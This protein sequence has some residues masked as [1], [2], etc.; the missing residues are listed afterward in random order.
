MA[1]LEL[2]IT[3]VGIIEIGDETN[4]PLR[5]NKRLS[6]ISLLTKRS[7]VYTYE[8]EIIDTKQNKKALQYFYHYK[9]NN[10][11]N[12]DE[13]KECVIKKDGRNFLEGKA[14]VK[15]STI[16]DGVRTFTVQFSG[17]N[18]DWWSELKKYT[19]A[20]LDWTG[21]AAFTQTYANVASTW[22]NTYT[23]GYV[24][25]LIDRGHALL[26]A[27][28]SFSYAHQSTF[29][30]ELFTR[31]VVDLISTKLGIIW[32]SDLFDEAGFKK[33]ILTYFTT[34]QY[35]LTSTIISDNHA[36]T[37]LSANGSANV[38]I[39]G[40][41]AT[42][43]DLSTVYSLPFT[44]WT[45]VIDTNSIVNSNGH[46]T[47]IL[48]GSIYKV[49]VNIN[50]DIYG[51]GHQHRVYFWMRNINNGTI[52]SGF[53]GYSNDDF[54]SF[55]FENTSSGSD[56]L[57][58]EFYLEAQAGDTYE[59]IYHI[60]DV[61][62][63]PNPNIAPYIDDD[64]NYVEPTISLTPNP[65][66][67][68]ILSGSRIEYEVVG[69]TIAHGI[70]SF[71]IGSIIDDT[72][73]LF[74]IFNDLVRTFNLYAE[75]DSVSNVVKIEPRKDFYGTIA[76]A[77]NL[78]SRLDTTKKIK[79]TFNST[80]Y[81]RY[82]E[83]KYAT[84]SRDGNLATINSYS[85][86]PHMS[87][88]H[89]YGEKFKEGK[90]TSSLSIIP[91][92]IDGVYFG[93]NDTNSNPS[94]PPITARC[95]SKNQQ[96]QPK[97]KELSKPRL[98]NYVYA[99]Q[100]A[101]ATG[102][103]RTFNN[104]WN[105]SGNTIIPAS[106]PYSDEGITAPYNLSFDSS[107]GLVATYHDDIIDII[108]TGSLMECYLFWDEEKYNNANFRR[109]KYFSEP[110]HL[111][112]Y[113]I[114]EAIE[115]YDPLNNGMYLTKFLK[116]VPSSGQGIMTQAD[117][118]Y[119]QKTTPPLYDGTDGNISGTSIS[120]NNIIDGSLGI[121]KGLTSTTSGQLVKGSYNEN[122]AGA[123]EVMGNGTTN[124]KSNSYI[125]DANGTKVHNP[126]VLSEDGDDI[127]Y[128]DLGEGSYKYI[129]T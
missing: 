126:E 58:F 5:L 17:G 36:I 88:V 102:V 73:S 127:Y 109:V 121:G 3:D 100:A 21:L 15:S 30:P 123:L 7:D 4:S 18:I 47:P 106:V 82:L 59:V 118:E 99:T 124:V 13:E 71:D 25:S 40:Y 128:E 84:D 91:A 27:N 103:N 116:V 60:E 12:I 51:Q 72:I 61:I 54:I 94:L 62:I 107:D 8:F 92:T 11:V 41:T 111:K 89:D 122:V 37:S 29:R 22:T 6:D 125:I 115:N 10:Y 120:Q 86:Y 105:S 77:E 110:E 31:Y 97:F 55:T 74:D 67:F 35:G 38:Q 76:N 33:L 20:D 104:W 43:A 19:L 81:N 75:T 78:T 39:A 57:Y 96:S 1:R 23:D 9:Y 50:I 64:G 79:T 117:I 90:R 98:L 32:D 45:D 80:K 34:E 2:E 24:F 56:S 66:N 101:D 53:P 129:Y 49:K 48:T 69:S 83:F 14:R 113:Y 68:Q 119:L 42:F 87:Y 63:I 26:I 85:K 52:A 114:L 65:V 70:D 44:L 112:G 28:N 108:E 16:I 95:W 46:I 93:S